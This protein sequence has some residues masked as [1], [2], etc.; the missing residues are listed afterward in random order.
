[1]NLWTLLLIS[2]MSSISS[3]ASSVL[4]GMD[5]LDKLSRINTGK[6]AVLAHH[7]SRDT[8]GNH[9]IDLSIKLGLQVTVIFAPEHGLRSTQ[10]DYVEDGI[11]PKTGLPIISLYKR[12]QRAPSDEDLKLFDTIIIDL[13]DVGVRYYTYAGT[14]YLSAKKAIEAGKKVIILDRVNPLGRTIS[15]PILNDELVGHTISFFK[16]PISHG[17]TI[18]EIMKFAFRDHPQKNNLSVLKNLNYNPNLT[19]HE[20]GLLWTL[21]SPA[22]PKYEQSYKYSVLGPLECLNLSVGRS[23]TNL[24]A[25]NY[26]GAPWMTIEE[27]IELVSKLN[28]LKLPGVKF[29]PVE[30][31]VTRS[32]FENQLARGFEFELEAF[33][34]TDRFKTLY[35]VMSTV[36]QTFKHRVTFNKWCHRYLGSSD[37]LEN[38]K[39]NVP[40][41]QVE[42]NVIKEQQSFK[43]ITN[44]YKLY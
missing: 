6:V 41:H 22:L 37:M 40:Y 7:A 38:V 20:L 32:I 24:E 19:W 11:D 2:L 10:D 31:R 34:K 3:F 12:Q 30:W 23:K 14:A 15:G 5:R 1:M 8:K 4:Q 18:G 39:K 43:S 27:S 26:Y 16:F 42:S 25:F 21:P 35:Q 29:S 36:V 9:L 28:E 13:K 44:A 17:L 33:S